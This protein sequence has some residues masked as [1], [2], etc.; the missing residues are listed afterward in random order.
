MTDGDGVCSSLD[1]EGREEEELLRLYI[2]LAGAGGAAAWHACRPI[3]QSG[4]AGQL[5][6]SGLV[7]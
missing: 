7:A 3:D 2:L 1:A 6:I 5:A 4:A